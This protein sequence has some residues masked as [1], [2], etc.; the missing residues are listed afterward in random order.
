MPRRTTLTQQTQIGLETTSGTSVAANKR[1]RS[2]GIDLSPEG[3]VRMFR[4]TGNK[5]NSIAAL[6]KEWSSGDVEGAATYTELVYLLSMMFGNATIT[7]PGGGTL[8]RQWE[9]LLQPSAIQDPRTFTVEKGSSVRAHKAAYVFLN[10]FGLEFTREEINVSGAV[11]G[12]S[13]TDGVTMTATPTDIALIPILPTQVSVY[14]DPSWATIGTTK[15]LSVISAN[16]ELGDR[17]GTFWP[18]D[19]AVSSFKD[20]YE[21]EPSAEVSLTQE[22]DAAGMANLTAMRAGTTQYLQIKAVGTIIEAAIAYSLI[23]DLPVKVSEVPSLEDED[24]IYGANWTF[25]LVDDTAAASAGR[26]RLINS[27]TTL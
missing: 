20:A 22:A 8:S 5:F 11:I 25:T 9:W 3:E 18:I 24:G 15:L 7:T 6:G 23:L 21:T 10:E 4:P 12:Q 16:L 27:L 13:I 19:A 1:L 17:F 26:I 14:L 2:V